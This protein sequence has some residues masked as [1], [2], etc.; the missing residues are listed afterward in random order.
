[1]ATNGNSSAAE[2]SDVTYEELIGMEYEYQQAELEVSKAPPSA[3]ILSR[4][5]SKS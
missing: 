2:P 5:P 4:P 3:S 1:M